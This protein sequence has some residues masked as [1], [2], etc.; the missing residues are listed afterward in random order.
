VA[1]A[2]LHAALVQEGGGYTL[3]IKEGV[4]FRFSTL[5][6][7]DGALARLQWIEDRNGNRIS[8]EY[9]GLGRLI[10]AGFS[11]T[12][13]LDFLYV[14]QT[15]RLH[16]IH[17]WSGRVWR[18][19]IDATGDLVGYTDPVQVARGA[20]GR[21]WKYEYYA[22]QRVAKLNH[23]LKRWVEPEDRDGDPL[24][25]GDVWM[26]F[27]YYDSDTVFQHESSTGEV[28]TFEY[29]F[30]RKRTTVTLPDGSREAYVYDR[31]GNLIRRK[32]RA[33]WPAATSMTASPGT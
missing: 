4:I 29:N 28:T 2:W 5:V 32:T 11:P 14:G 15:S 12:R 25:A 6:E 17:D 19:S 9:D 26:S 7:E 30:L 10:H 21:S 1:P 24:A 3:T 33:V 16:E 22:D 8:C 20:Q 27:T 13:R 18:Y 23:N 31:F